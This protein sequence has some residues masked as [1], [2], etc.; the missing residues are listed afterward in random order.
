MV[1]YMTA[2]SKEVK[3]IY[4]LGIMIRDKVVGVRSIGFIDIEESGERA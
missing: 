1:G 4:F 3:L 2:V